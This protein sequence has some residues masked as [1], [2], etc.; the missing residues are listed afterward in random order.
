M[1]LTKKKE[2]GMIGLFFSILVFGVLIYTGTITSGWHLVDD[3]EYI[4]YMLQMEQDGASYFECLADTILTD[5]TWRFRPL[6]YFLR[7]TL[8]VLIGDNLVI[9]S[10]IK[11]MVT[12]TAFFF[13]YMCARELKC[14]IFPSVLFSMVVMVGPQSVVWWKLGPQECTGMMIFSIGFYFMLKWMHTGKR[15]YNWIAM[16][17]LIG[18]GIYKESFLMMIPFAISY[19]F[20]EDIKADGFRIKTLW[21]SFKKNMILLCSLIITL[22]VSLLVIFLYSGTSVGFHDSVMTPNAYKLLW[23]NML[24]NSLQWFVCFVIPIFIIMLTGCRKWTKLIWEILLTM[25]VMIPQFILYIQLGFE[26]RYII[27]WVFGYAYFVV[28]ALGNWEVM[29][30]MRR[31]LWYCCVIGL[32]V[33]HF[34][35]VI[36]EGEYYTYRGH[37]VT[38]VFEMVLKES[39]PDTKILAAYTPY[40]ESDLTLSAW[41]RYNGRDNVYVWDNDEGTC[42]DIMGVGEGNIADVED[43]DY[44]LFYN[45]QDRHYCYEPNIDLNNYIKTEYGTLVIC[46]KK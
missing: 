44:I 7:V 32:L 46:R 33:V 14:S 9:W 19:L 24:Q 3:Q 27:P 11:G 45:P 20:Y 29:R 18:A 36:A 2:L 43:M 21:N 17:F 41:M 37:S 26:E 23:I 30:G 4:C 1:K 34:P 6:Y 35:I 42:T 31:K 12:V 8:T 28:I 16:L 40:D 39:T 15:R 10:V 25:A 13:L 22:V 38:T 5:L